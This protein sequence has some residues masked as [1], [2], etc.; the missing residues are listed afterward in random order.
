MEKPNVATIIGKRRPKVSDNGAHRIG[1]KANPRTNREVPRVPTSVETL[2]R[3]ETTPTAGAKILLAVE[4][5]RAKKAEMAPMYSLH[6]VNS[7]ALPLTA[8]EKV[9][10][11]LKHRPI[12][13]AEKVIGP[14]KVHNVVL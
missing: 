1:P 3:L 8:S 2:N 13:S 7:G 5:L 11:L 6:D 4:V 12:L 10:I 9:G 14:I